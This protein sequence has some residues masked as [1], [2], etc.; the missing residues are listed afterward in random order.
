M[1]QI[2]QSL[3]SIEV[4]EMVGKQ[5]SELLKDIRRYCEQLG[6]VDIPLTS[7]F[8]EGSYQS[9][10][11][12]SLPCFLVTKKGCEFIGNKLTGTKG[13]EFTARYIIKFH[14]MESQLSAMVPKTYKDAILQLL[15]HIEENEHLQL[16]NLTMKPKAE[17]FDELVDRNLLTSFRDTAKELGIKEKDFIS[18]LTGRKYIYRDAKRNLKAYADKNNGL[19]ELKEFTSRHSD[20]TG[21]QT[22]ITPRGRETFRLL[23]KG[24]E[25]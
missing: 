13:T 7:F 19:F 9:G 25:K 16:E 6:E 14:E 22:L 15:Q 5:H 20:H 3:T 10:Q 12:K 1:N 21:Q 4:A 18:F 8:T 2:E 23:I 24:E 11:N 17:Y